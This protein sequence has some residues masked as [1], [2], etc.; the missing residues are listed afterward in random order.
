MEQMIKYFCHDR[1][2]PG[3]DM[4]W[5]LLEYEIYR[6]VPEIGQ[7]ISAGLTYSISAAISFKIVSLGTYT[8]R[9]HHG[10]NFPYWCRSR[11]QSLTNVRHC[12]KTAFL[13]FHFQ[14]GKQSE[15]TGGLSPASR[16]D[17]ER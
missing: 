14:S 15:I 17:G 16:E 10:S 9:K 3:Q 13:Q 5:L 7:K 4:N 2:Y 6:K 11:L 8:L 12:F 1:W